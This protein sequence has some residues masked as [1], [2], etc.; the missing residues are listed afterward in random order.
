ML[1]RLVWIALLLTSPLLLGPPVGCCADTGEQSWAAKRNKMAAELRAWGI[2][3]SSVL[4]ALKAVPRHLF[5]PEGHRARAYEDTP[6]PIGLRQ[7]ISAPSIVALMTELVRPEPGDRVLDVGTGSGYQAAVL[8][9]LVAEV[10]SIEI[11]CPLAEEARERLASLGY[12]NIEVRCGDGYRGWPE[13]APFDAIILAAA[14]DHVPPALIEQLAP[15]GR[16]VLPVG[17][18]YQELIL[19]EKDRKGNVARRSVLPVRFVPMTGEA[20]EK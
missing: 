19:I 3:D 9:E 2:A 18:L 8:A 6:L 16:L 7:T 17:D 12:E 1:R 14:P 11:L 20:Q 10:W 13:Q 4:G 15:R 5:V